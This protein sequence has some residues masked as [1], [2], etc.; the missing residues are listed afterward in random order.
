MRIRLID[1]YGFMLRGS[2]PNFEDN[3]AKKLISEGRAIALSE[4][5]THKALEKPNKD[6][7]VRRG[8][9]KKLNHSS[10]R[11]SMEKRKCQ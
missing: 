1:N 9:K 7:M 5:D 11:G 3:F 10:N 6:K 8:R 4:S 2:T